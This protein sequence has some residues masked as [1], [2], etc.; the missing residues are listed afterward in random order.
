MAF[1]DSPK[2][3]AIWER[4]LSA[5]REEKEERKKNGFAPTDRD[6]QTEYQAQSPPRRKI[7]LKQLEEKELSREGIR[8]V[9]RPKR[10]MGAAKQAEKKQSMERKPM[11]L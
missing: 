3:R 8:R 11:G 7:T 1:F 10:A 6:A 2:N 4:R 5:L 9:K